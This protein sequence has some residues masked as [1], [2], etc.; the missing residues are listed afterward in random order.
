MTDSCKGI[1]KRGWRK[2]KWLLRHPRFDGIYEFVRLHDF[3]EG[4]KY[5]SRCVFQYDIDCFCK[6]E[7][8]CGNIGVF[9]AEDGAVVIEAAEQLAKVVQ[10]TRY[11]HRRILSCRFVNLSGEFFQ[12]FQ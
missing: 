1:Q 10:V 7:P 3:K 9:G 11:K 2:S 5:Q 12:F 8:G 6:R 4:N